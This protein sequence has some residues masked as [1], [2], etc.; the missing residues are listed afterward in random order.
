[1]NFEIKFLEFGGM[2]FKRKI[3]FSYRKNNVI[4]LFILYYDLWSEICIYSYF[5]LFYF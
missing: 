1:M 5:L 4:Y 2:E 3:K